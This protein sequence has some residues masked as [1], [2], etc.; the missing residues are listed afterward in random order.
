M[1]ALGKNLRDHGYTSAGV[2]NTDGFDKEEPREE[3]VSVVIDVTSAKEGNVKSN[4]CHRRVTDAG[5]AVEAA[6]VVVGVWVVITELRE[7]RPDSVYLC[8]S[9]E[10]AAQEASAEIGQAD[11]KTAS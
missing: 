1:G 10:Q 5:F 11:V 6:R 9:A 3:E 8:Q 4:S 7:Q 2:R